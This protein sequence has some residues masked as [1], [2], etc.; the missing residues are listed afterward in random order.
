[1]SHKHTYLTNMQRHIHTY[2]TNIQRH[3]HKHTN[4]NILTS[5]LTTK[6]FSACL[7]KMCFLMKSGPLNFF[8]DNWHNHLPLSNSSELTLMNF[9][10]SVQEF[11]VKEKHQFATLCLAI[12]HKYK[13]LIYIQLGLNLFLY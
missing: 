3:I 12:I 5:L 10:T 6:T 7:V 11:K 8:P 2:I 1:M 9:S 13:L 4:I